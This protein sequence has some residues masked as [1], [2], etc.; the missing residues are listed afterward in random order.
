VYSPL[1][2]VIKPFSGPILQVRIVEESRVAE[3]TILETDGGLTNIGTL[4]V[5]SIASIASACG[6]KDIL[7]SVSLSVVDL[8][9][10]RLSVDTQVLDEQNLG[11]FLLASVSTFSINFATRLSTTHP[12]DRFVL[13]ASRGTDPDLL[14]VVGT[15]L[16]SNALQAT[17][18]TKSIVPLPGTTPIAIAAAIVQFGQCRCSGQRHKDNRQEQLH[19]RFVSFFSVSTS[20][21]KVSNTTKRH[22]VNTS[23]FGHSPNQFSK[24]ASPRKAKF[25]SPA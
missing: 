1:S 24:T 22:R 15:D 20:T 10:D 5:V 19:G 18:A 4:V 12:T 13:L 25:G 11:R 2:H 8:H 7:V 14:L 21:V 23:Y 9:C 17:A 6:A 3:G 16:V